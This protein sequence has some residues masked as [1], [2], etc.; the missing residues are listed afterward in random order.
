MVTLKTYKW[1]VVVVSLQYMYCTHQHT[2]RMCLFAVYS[3][4]QTR[5]AVDHRHRPADDTT[6]ET[7]HRWHTGEY[8][9]SCNSNTQRQYMYI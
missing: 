4:R 2:R 5:A 3:G 9:H 8:K 7:R 1:V 6:K